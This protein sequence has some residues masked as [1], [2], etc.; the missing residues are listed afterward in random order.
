MK[1]AIYVFAIV[2]LFTC[3]GCPWVLLHK[4]DLQNYGNDLRIY[5]K[6]V[7]PVT[8]HEGGVINPNE[9]NELGDNLET[10]IK[11]WW[12]YKPPKPALVPGGNP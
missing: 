8:E 6:Y 5:R 2:I 11:N 9:V 3:Y 1:V 7:I 4:N 12:G 10:I